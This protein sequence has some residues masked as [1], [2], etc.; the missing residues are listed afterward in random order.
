MMDYTLYTF[1]RNGAA[2]TTP[3]AGYTGSHSWWRNT[4]TPRFWSVQGHGQFCESGLAVT[5]DFGNL[6]RVPA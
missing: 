3:N 1:F 6:V 4:I 2:Y 5:D